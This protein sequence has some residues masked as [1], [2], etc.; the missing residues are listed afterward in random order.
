[1]TVSYFEENLFQSEFLLTSTEARRPIGDGDEWERE[2]E[3]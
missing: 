3:E 1:M 2:I